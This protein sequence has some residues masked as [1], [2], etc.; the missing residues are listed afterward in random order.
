MKKRNFNRRNLLRYLGVSS[1]GMAL[2]GAAIN[3]R[4]KIKDIPIDAK[5]EVERLKN[6]VENLKVTYEQLDKRSK[7]ILRLILFTSGLDIYLG[8]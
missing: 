2:A 5:Q 6:E 7:I 3:V 4:E 8:L 1:A